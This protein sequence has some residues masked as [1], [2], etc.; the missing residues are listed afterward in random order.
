MP[1]L[2]VYY[3]R[4][5]AAPPRDPNQIDRNPPGTSSRANRLASGPA[6]PGSVIPPGPS[7]D[8]HSAHSKSASSTAD[9]LDETRTLRGQVTEGTGS[10]TPRESGRGDK[11]PTRYHQE[12]DS[13]V[14]GNSGIIHGIIGPFF[15]AE[16]GY[17]NRFGVLDPVGAVPTEPKLARGGSTEAASYVGDPIFVCTASRVRW[18]TWIR[19]QDRLAVCARVARTSVRPS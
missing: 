18:S 2:I 16:E 4:F 13:V 6:T 5:I 7:S 19:F 3:P 17:L 10:K 14:S 15:I 1:N 11:T 8:P 12:R 9:Q